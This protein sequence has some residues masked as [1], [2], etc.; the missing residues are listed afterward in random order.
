MTRKPLRQLFD[1]MHHNKYSFEDFLNLRMAEHYVKVPW[2]DRVI[3]KPSKTL[4]AMQAFLNNL[5]FEYLPINERVSF[6]YRKG[7]FLLDAVT[8][9]TS[10]RAFYQTDFEK[11]FDSITDSTI[12][13]VVTEALTPADDLFNYIDRIIELTTVD[14]KLPIGFSTSPLLSNACLKSLDDYLEQQCASRSWVYSRYA[15]D[16]IVSAKSL[17]GI[18]GVEQVIEQ[19]VTESL[20]SGFRIN[21]SKSRLTTVGRKIKVL[22][23][24]IL[25]SGRVTIDRELRQ[26]VE[27]QL[28]Y[29]VTDRARLEHIYGNKAEEGLLRLSGYISYIYTADPLYFEKLQRKFGIT[30]IDSLLHRSVQ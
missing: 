1:A 2:R 15:D 10:S 11:F 20:G 24:V 13:Q 23:L 4:K 12:R 30:V 9:H 14:G 22:G 26:K 17:S 25:P 21:Q 5:V 16:I 8:P 3:Y 27:W 7:A 29:F 18:D 19:S 6:A 28:H